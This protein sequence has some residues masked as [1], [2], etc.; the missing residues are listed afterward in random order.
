MKRVSTNDISAVWRTDASIQ[1][2]ACERERG[3]LIHVEEEAS[4]YGH[5]MRPGDVKQSG[6]NGSESISPERVHVDLV[7]LVA[8]GRIGSGR[9]RL[10]R[11]FAR[12]DFSKSASTMLAASITNRLAAKRGHQWRLYDHFTAGDWRKGRWKGRQLSS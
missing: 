4:R 1:V 10:R 7:R 12:R 2:L 6:P 3:W 9:K 11:S 8:V 5:Y